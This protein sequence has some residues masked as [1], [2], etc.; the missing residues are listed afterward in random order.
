MFEFGKHF[1]IIVVWML[2]FT[3]GCATLPKDFERP[4]SYAYEDTDDTRLG[5]ARRN[6]ETAH[7]GQSGFLLLGNG[8]DAFVARAVLAD[9]ADRSID[10]QYY[11]FHSDL[12]GFLL[13]DQLLKAAD[14][15]VR[16][17]LLV[18]DM[19]LA[20]RDL[21]AAVLDSHPNMEVRI[22]NPFSRKTFRMIQFVTRIGSVTR[23]MHNKSFIVDN[24]AAI[25]GGRNIGNE[26]F[27]ADPDFAFA[28]LD[29]LVIGAVVEKISAS[30]DEY[31]NSDLAYPAS[32]LRGRPTSAEEIAEKRKQLDDFIEQQ[33]ES[34]YSQALRDSGLANRMREN[35]VQFQWADAEVIYDQPEKILHDK[36]EVR[37][38]LAPKIKPYFEDVE[39][40][41]I[42]FSPYFVPGKKGVASLAQLRER[43][44]RVRILTNSLASTDVGIVHAGYGKYRRDMLRSGIELYEMNKKARTQAEKAK[45]GIPAS[46]KASLHAKSF[47]FDRKKVFIGSLNL[48][49]R[50]VVHNTEIGVVFASEEIATALSEW[51]DHNIEKIAFRLELKKY[52]SGYEQILWHGFEEGKP[53]VYKADPHTNFLRRLGIGFMGLLP[54]ESQL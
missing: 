50:A 27:N 32:V 19:D 44:V 4:T 6:E 16:V 13:F 9:R 40:E 36:D 20:G 28:D 21:G 3:V 39:K 1:S 7:P 2:L 54:I 24:Q 47:I 11:L 12:V 53:C 33:K 22:F 52:N 14:R 37:L 31:W 42:I 10:A 51:F 29:V 46:S 38:H 41:L 18:D 5:E 43:G 26:Y 45:K 34:A 30:F 8:L 23:R 17:R 35:S 48:D 15:G 25:V 49:P